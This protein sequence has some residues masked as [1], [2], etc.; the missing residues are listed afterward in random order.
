[1]GRMLTCLRLAHASERAGTGTQKTMRLRCDMAARFLQIWGY[2]EAIHKVGKSIVT[3]TA[4]CGSFL[5]TLG[6]S[7]APYLAN[8]PFDL[9]ILA[10]RWGWGF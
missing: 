3:K 6:D 2:V 8:G 9:S 10:G 4:V 5:S 1:M 7:E